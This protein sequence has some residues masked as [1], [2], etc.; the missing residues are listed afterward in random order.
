MPKPAENTEVVEKPEHVSDPAA[1]QAAE[2]VAAIS[3]EA[4]PKTPDELDKLA[5]S[6]FDAGMA[7]AE[8]KEPPKS[9]PG[10][11]EDAVVVEPKKDAAGKVIEEPKAEKPDAAKP[12]EEKPAAVAGAKPDEK[13][14][15]D[16]DPVVEKQIKDLNLGEKASTRFRE[17]NTEVKAFEPF[18]K[19]IEAAGIKTVEQIPDIV[20]QAARAADM[21]AAFEATGAT[22]DQF[23]AALGCLY[24]INSGDPKLMME[25]YNQLRGQ[26]SELAQKLG[27]P[28]EGVDP[29]DADPELK[30]RVEKGDMNR[31]DAERIVAGE[32]QRKLVEQ[33]DARTRET[34]A[35]KNAIDKGV[36]DIKAL[37][38]ELAG[39]DP[40]N[41][42]AKLKYLG[43]SI[44][45]IQQKMAPHEWKDAIRKLYNESPAPPRVVVP[46]PSREDSQP[47]RPTPVASHQVT[48]KATSDMDA[49]E[50]GLELANKVGGG[51]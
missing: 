25:A 31:D 6:A 36:E 37:G 41:Y 26:C 18:K 28:A 3:A 14:K 24:G 27:L 12:V 34:G 38:A 2:A 43:P 15:P 13:A 46:I 35:K 7:V 39:A 40:E 49:F 16:P 19:A 11:S 5:M 30:A 32:A 44:A 20:H 45:I 4:K 42:A 10:D 9:R 21:D 17:L 23:G 51:W 29:L 48:S 22:P 33:R 8:G 50:K 1:V 47:L